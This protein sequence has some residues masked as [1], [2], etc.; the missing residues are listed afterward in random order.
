MG[1]KLAQLI[2]D[3]HSSVCVCVRVF[4]CVPPTFTH[5]SYTPIIHIYT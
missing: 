2:D 5:N 3:D 1:T 4:V